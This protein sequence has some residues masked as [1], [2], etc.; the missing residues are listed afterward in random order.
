MKTKWF[1]LSYKPW[2]TLYKAFSTMVQ[3]YFYAHIFLWIVAIVVVKEHFLFILRNI[4][5][6][7]MMWKEK[8]RKKKEI[9]GYFEL[10]DYMIW[11]Y[12]KSV[13][14]QNQSLYSCCI[15]LITMNKTMFW[16]IAYIIYVLEYCILFHSFNEYIHVI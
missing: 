7:F 11:R 3:S 9:I 6:L 8:N 2:H 5:Q 14:N 12:L 15:N 16:N 10:Q 13:L 4:Y 1:I